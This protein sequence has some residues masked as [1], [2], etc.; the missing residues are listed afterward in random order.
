MAAH[1][2]HRYALNLEW[3]GNLGAGTRTYRGYSRNHVLRAPGKPEIPGSSDPA[4]RG[5]AGRY[6]PEELLVAALSSCHMLWYLHL[7]AEAG[8][9]V[10]AYTDSP[11]GKMVET[12]DGGG[13][14]V[15]VLLRPGVT[16]EPGGAPE[17]A[18]RL[19][20]RAHHLCFIANSVN[21]PMRCEPAPVQIA[22]SA[23]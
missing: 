7:C 6:N 12:E 3:I 14:F 9:V 17:T 1:K 10:T 11:E 4:F 2:E 5:D 13:R 19:H 21:F 18:V 23:L 8:I 16:I 22:H 15:E 20:E